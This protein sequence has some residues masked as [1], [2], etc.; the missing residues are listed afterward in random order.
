M[1]EL[2][3]AYNHQDYENKIYEAWEK[4]NFFAPKEGKGKPFCVIMPPPNSNGS[5]HLGP[6]GF[7]HPGRHHDPLSP[8]QRRTGVVAARALTTPVLKRRWSLKKIGKRRQEPLGLAARGIVSKN[9]GL[10]PNQQSGDG[11]PAPPAG[12]FLRLVA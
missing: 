12:R 11:R 3:K 7:C 9:V 5:L 4:G 1:K 2:A 10:Y 6:C 8:P